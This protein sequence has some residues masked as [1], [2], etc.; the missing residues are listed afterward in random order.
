MGEQKYQ[1]HLFF[2]EA[3]REQ[4]EA[5]AHKDERG[6]KADKSED[7]LLQLERNLL[8]LKFALRDGNENQA[9]I[10]AVNVANFAMMVWDVIGNEQPVAGPKS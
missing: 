5:N 9:I 3:M 10:R 4:L 6:W 8:A 7:L 2:T 1:A